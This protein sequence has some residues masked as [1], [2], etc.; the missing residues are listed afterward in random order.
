LKTPSKKA[1]FSTQKT[2]FASLITLLHFPKNT[3]IKTKL[4]PVY[5]RRDVLIPTENA[6]AIALEINDKKYI[7]LIVHQQTSPANTFY[8][9]EDTLVRGEVVLIEKN[10][11]KNTI[12]IIK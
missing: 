4:L 1:A 12:T 2:G 6:E 9:V 11:N 7:L 8:K 3:T 5:S 10:K